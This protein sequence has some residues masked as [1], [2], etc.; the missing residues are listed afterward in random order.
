MFLHYNVFFFKVFWTIIS[1]H[2]SRRSK[3]FTISCLTPFYKVWENFICTFISE[4]SAIIFRT[5]FEYQTRT[6]LHS[7]KRFLTPMKTESQLI[8]TNF[9]K[10]TSI[11]ANSHR[12]MKSMIE[13]W[14]SAAFNQ[15]TY[16]KLTVITLLRISRN[17]IK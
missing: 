7:S 4:I 13:S 12:R 2:S 6:F 15:R 17:L 8:S 14:F 9:V 5:Y 11:I 1:T 16:L 10:S 3:S